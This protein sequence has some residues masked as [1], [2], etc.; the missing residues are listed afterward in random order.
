MINILSVKRP[1]AFLHFLPPPCANTKVVICAIHAE[2]Q[3]GESAV[4]LCFS[5]LN[6]WTII[7][8]HSRKSNI[9]LSNLAL[10]DLY[11]GIQSLNIKWRQNYVGW[12]QYTKIIF[13]NTGVCQESVSCLQ[14]LGSGE[15]FLEG[16]LVIALCYIQIALKSIPYKTKNK[17]K[18]CSR[19]VDFSLVLWSADDLK[20]FL[21]FL[22]SIPLWIE[23][24]FISP[25]SLKHSMACRE[26]FL[27]KL[28][29]AKH[30]ITSFVF[31]S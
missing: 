25:F 6:C 26:F 23:L 1:F 18:F 22:S 20:S 29:S 5:N 3:K 21:S 17:G 30:T 24:A 11:S 27:S 2:S 28:S 13:A 9:W 16:L 19:N 4:F 12:G 7:S 10:L 31:G 15:L 14:S 8:A